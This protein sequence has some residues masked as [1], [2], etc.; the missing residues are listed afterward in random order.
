M[1]HNKMNVLERIKQRNEKKKEEKQSKFE[2]ASKWLALYAAILTTVLTSITFAEKVTPKKHEVDIYV[3]DFHND[4]EKVDFTIAYYNSGDFFEVLSAVDLYLA[5]KIEGKNNPMYWDQ[6]SC[7]EPILLEPK[8]T[9]YMTYSAKV[10]FT[11]EKLYV[12]EDQKSKFELSLHFD[13][14]SKEHGK[15][16][17]RFSVATLTP[18][19]GKFFENTPLKNKSEIDFITTKRKVDFEDARPVIIKSQ[20]P[21][22]SEF[23]SQNFCSKKI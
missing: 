22:S 2:K 18:Y 19:L 4:D 14:L 17:V 16:S 20:Y 8:K 10:N 21:V 7:R 15:A 6:A 11:D 5:Q 9:K 3:A 23:V 1:P 13:F 12:F